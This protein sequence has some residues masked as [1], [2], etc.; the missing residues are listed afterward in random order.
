MENQ[1]DGYPIYTA[2]GRP[3]ELGQM[4]GAQAAEQIR[5]FLDYLQ[6]TLRLDRATIA[7]RAMRF[8]PL[9]RQFC[10]HLLEEVAGLAQGASI[11]LPEALAVQLRGELT[12]V[13][14]DACTAF[15]IP[16]RLSADGGTLIGQNSD[17]PPELIRFGYVLRLIPEHGPRILIWTFGGMIGYHGI[18]SH[19]VA[20]F[21]NALGGGPGWRFA[22]SHYPLKRLVLEQ[23]DLPAVRS[24][25]RA[26]PVCS[27]GNYVLCDGRGEIT[28][29][30]LTSAGPQ[31]LPAAAGGWIVHSNHYHCAAHC[32]PENLQQSLP[33]SLT[34]QSRL[35]HLLRESADPLSVADLKR[36]LSDHDGFPTGICRHA[37][38]GAGVDHPMLASSGQ[39]VAALIAKP[40]SGLL[41]ISRGNPC[42]T[43]FTTYRLDD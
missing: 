43:P 24:L 20:H 38:A 21:A 28:D 17:N 10:P 4:H 41:H 15:A 30:E 3:R 18:N 42:Q 33:D 37:H 32:S 6:T 13:R 9:F 14:D 39:T 31:E 12:G 2:C 1:P 35:E 5:G 23:H 25:M 16:R 40:D 8:E 22:L 19:G 36:F 27:N 7:N 34:R 29:I 26:I 11:S